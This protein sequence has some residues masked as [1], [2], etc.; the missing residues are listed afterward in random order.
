MSSVRSNN[1]SVKY[2]KIT[3]SDCKDIGIRRFEKLTSFD[4]K[5]FIIK[6]R[7]ISDLWLGAVKQSKNCLKRKQ[8]FP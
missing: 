8:I 2:Q 6:W 3:Q 7:K 4:Q 1:L 5:S